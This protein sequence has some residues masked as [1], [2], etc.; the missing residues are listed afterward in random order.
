MLPID[1]ARKAIKD[2]T[3]RKKIT[4]MPITIPSSIQKRAS[5]NHK[6]KLET[7]LEFC[8]NDLVKINITLS[9]LGYASDGSQELLAKRE[10]LKEEISKLESQ[11]KGD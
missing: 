7:E 3:R 9:I 1:L 10:S 5:S 6:Q 11:L 2:P 4:I 8:R